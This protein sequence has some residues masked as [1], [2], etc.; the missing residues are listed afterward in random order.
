M[1]NRQNELNGLL[2]QVRAKYEEAGKYTMSSIDIGRGV[3][4]RTAR[5]A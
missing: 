4:V 5:G 3:I 2:G 1:Q